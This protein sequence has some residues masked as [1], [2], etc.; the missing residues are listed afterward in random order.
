M[1]SIAVTRLTKRFGA[2]HAVGPLDL[3]IAAGEFVSLLGPSGCGKTTT[4]R[5]IAGFETPTAGSIRI[6]NADMH[7]VAVERRG[8]GMVFQSYALFPH[9]SVFDNVAFGLR[10][11]RRPRGDIE[12]AVQHVL[13]L[14]DLAEYGGRMPRELSGG[15]QQRVA[16]A[17]A[18]AVQPAVLL[19]DEPLSNLD[20]KLREQM[21]DE[22][23]RLQ[24]RVGITAL[25]VTH[26]QGE[27]MAMSDRI[28]V[29]NRGR[30]EQIGTPREVYERPA[31][32]FVA[33]F[34]GQ[35]TVLEG[36]L[37]AIE[38]TAARFVS[39]AGTPFAVECAGVAAAA[40]R[41]AG[42]VIRPEFV[43]VRAA[44]ADGV[45]AVNVMDAIV[46]EAV[47]VGERVD[48]TVRLPH[49]DSIVV[50]QRASPGRALPQ[51]GDRVVIAVSPAELTLVPLPEGAET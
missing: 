28:V 44:A 24:R 7:G 48:L 25:Y 15:Q 23:R 4:L 12:K 18:L 27:A 36:R 13:G 45:A 39:R 3:T 20:L 46:E 47:Y 33:R 1:A 42:L 17:R 51:P 9:L 2:T 50:A 16:L 30:V 38:G 29:M 19:L 41:A 22:I 26:D 43:E 14:V 35:C 32:L 5:M 49:G 40:G 37:D 6:G 34:I 8:I 21:R 31:S 10:L 11:K